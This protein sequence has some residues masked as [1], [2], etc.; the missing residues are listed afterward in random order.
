MLVNVEQGAANPSVGTLLRIGDALGLGLPAL[1]E[2]TRPKPARVTRDGKGAVLW[3]SPSGGR[4]M[5]VAST[6][7]PDVVDLWDWTLGRGD[8]HAGEA[9]TPGTRELVQVQ[10]G[11]LTVDVAGTSYTLRT[12]DA[13]SFPDSSSSIRSRRSPSSAGS[14]WSSSPAPLR[15][16]AADAH[17]R[18]ANTRPLQGK[19]ISWT[20]AEA[21]RARTAV[22]R[23]VTVPGSCPAM[24]SISAVPL[25]GVISHGCV[26][27]VGCS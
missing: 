8:V 23:P 11:T 26:A 27:K 14:R 6:E 3:S 13:V 12:G 21:L 22:Q 16:A 5:L 15:S 24:T 10:R 25:S 18:P 4:G 9:H 19:G 17:N 20:S 2:S 1:V 7:P